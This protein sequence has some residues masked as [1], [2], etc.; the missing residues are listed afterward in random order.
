MLT[1]LAWGFAIAMTVT[2]AAYAGPNDG[3]RPGPSAPRWLQPRAPSQPYALTGSSEA[4]RKA[5]RPT[6]T[7]WTRRTRQI[8]NKVTIDSFE[9]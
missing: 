3:I 5:R 6:S 8:G 4:S 7:G 2:S 1:R 9:R